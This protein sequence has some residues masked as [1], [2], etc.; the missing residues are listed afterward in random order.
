MHPGTRVHAP[1]TLSDLAVTSPKGDVYNRRGT[2][3]LVGYPR[4][5]TRG[6][7]NTGASIPYQDREIRAWARRDGHRI[8]GMF[9]EEGRSGALDLEDRVALTAAIDLV[10][11]G[12]AEGLVCYSL[13]RLAREITVQEAILAKVWEEAGGG[14]SLPTRARFCATTRT[15]QCGLRCGKWPGHVRAGPAPDRRSAAPRPPAQGRADQLNAEQESQPNVAAPWRWTG[16]LTPPV[17]LASQ[18]P[19]QIAPHAS[20]EML[21]SRTRGELRRLDPRVRSHPSLPLGLRP[22]ARWPALM[23]PRSAVD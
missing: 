22:S 3:R 8:V 1:R 12:K 16:R 9:P 10:A 11:N 21:P 5:S 7:V 2:L 20:T 19:Q 15:T 23:S 14:S 6:Q 17:S 18:R 13:D 4:V